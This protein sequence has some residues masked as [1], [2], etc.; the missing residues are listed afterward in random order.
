VV[1]LVPALQKVLVIAI[2]AVVGAGGTALAVSAFSWIAPSPSPQSPP[3][4]ALGSVPKSVLPA[5]ALAPADAA[6]PPI[7]A[8]D[9][10]PIEIDV[11]VSWSEADREQARE[12]K[13]VQQDTRSCLRER[14]IEYRYVAPWQEYDDEGALLDVPVP[15][16]DW[17]AEFA[18]PSM[19]Y[20]DSSK[21]CWSRAL[22]LSG[23]APAGSLDFPTRLPRFEPADFTDPETLDMPEEWTADEREQGA[24]E[25]R[26]ELITRQCMA[27][28]GFPS[29]G[30]PPTWLDRGRTMREDPWTTTLS[31]AD[32]ERAERALNGESTDPYD[33]EQAGCWG[34]GVHEADPE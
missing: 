12:W 1:R 8:A 2:V 9:P 22:V 33:W 15:P 21:V 31:A 30:M 11:P 32:Q 24:R 6:W 5:P 17:T 25:W 29:Y 7:P 19:S 14:G 3:A 23:R 4:R 16:A 20:L 34:R 28:A 26:A 18:K 10:D 27:D 13:T